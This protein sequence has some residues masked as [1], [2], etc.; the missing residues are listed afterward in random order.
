MT[1]PTSTTHPATRTDA[2]QWLDEARSLL[3]SQEQL[4]GWM[5]LDLD[6]QLRYRNGILV[7]T[8]ERLLSHHNGQSGW[9]SHPLDA[10]ASLTHTDQFGVGHFSLGNGTSV[11][12]RWHHT[13]NHGSAARQLTDAF[14]HHTQRL[15]TTSGSTIEPEAPEHESR[16]P[17]EVQSPPSTWALFRLWRFARP[18]QWPLFI[19]FM[20]TLASTAAALVPPYL[21]MPLMDKVLIPFQNGKAIDWPLVQYYLGGLLLA[22]LLA[23]V[24]GWGRTYILAKVSERIGADLRTTAY[25][26]LQT[27]SLQ[28]FGGKRTGDLISRIG[29]ESD[30]LCVF[31]SLHLLDFLTDV[32]MIVMT[33]VILFSINPW[34]A[35]VTLIPLPFIVWLIH[36]VR[37]RLRHG[38]E[39]AD[40]VWSELTNVL[41]DTIPGIRVVKAFA[42]EQ[43]ETRRFR[44][45]NDR[46][47]VI[48][49]RVNRLWAL[50]SPT[51]TFLTEVGLLVV[52]G[53]GIWLVSVEEITV[54][55]LT[56]FLTYISR[57][58]IRLDAMSRIVSHTQRA[59]A[60]AKRIFDI[61]DHVSSVPEPTRPRH[62]ETVKGGLQLNRIGFRYG[63]RQV[64]RNLS[65]DIKPGEMIGLV[66]HSGSGKSTLVNLIC[67][68]YDVTEGGIRIDGIDIRELP[69]AEFRRH[70]GLVLQE[71]FLFFGTIAENIAYG[72]PEASRDEIIAAAKAA[73]AHEFI[74]RL[75]HGYDS[76]VGERGQALSG[77]ERQRISIARALLIDPR[78]L[79]LDEATSSVDTTTEKEI[80][81]ALDNLVKGRTTISIAHR[82]STLHKADRLVVMDKGVIVE[83]GRHD[84]LLAKNGAYARLYQAQ[85]QL[86]ETPQASSGGK[87]DDN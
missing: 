69:V 79:I 23:W 60:G 73:H 22:S 87:D 13:L 10:Q 21:T 47:L 35:V 66:G 12:R 40:R 49:D 32:L 76:L 16:A 7:L 38:F 51:V 80:Q 81:K 1:T 68:F 36:L 43:R 58:Y 27:L 78:I 11:V 64:I 20:L 4:L 70:I 71:P 65:L 53:F 59:A 34:L 54:G 37:D 61:L 84:D 26:H 33:A 5:P 3:S 77:G 57:F 83:T 52:W 85:A 31:L 48:N 55:V 62:L 74:L 15:K 86:N 8:S 41:T 28:Y 39:R 30:R 72:K 46:N 25:Q 6:D 18:Y 19:G 24:L 44:E 82:L 42:Q 45:A 56:A 17:E 67:R 29:S 50:F 75:P 14:E 63:S 2:R 9:D